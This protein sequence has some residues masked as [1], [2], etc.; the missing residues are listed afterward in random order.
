MVMGVY[1][2]K[3]KLACACKHMEGQAFFPHWNG[4]G[5]VHRTMYVGCCCCGCAASAIN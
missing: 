1:I 5:C 2:C 3:H 4:S